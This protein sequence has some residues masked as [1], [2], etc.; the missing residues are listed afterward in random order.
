MRFMYIRAL[1][2]GFHQIRWL[3]ARSNDVSL[4]KDE[5]IRLVCLKSD[6]SIGLV[7]QHTYKPCG[8]SAR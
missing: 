7:S 4:I 8:K 3:L 5:K 6:T 1:N 2:C